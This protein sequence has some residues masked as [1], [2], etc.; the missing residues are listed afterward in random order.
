MTVRLL[1]FTRLN[2]LQPSCSR[3]MLV[4]N[5]SISDNQPVKV[6]TGPVLRIV[7]VIDYSTSD[8]SDNTGNFLDVALLF[9]T[10]HNPLYFT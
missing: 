4:E 10:Q 1:F 3:E 7:D 2:K 9:S 8:Y 5:D 6:W